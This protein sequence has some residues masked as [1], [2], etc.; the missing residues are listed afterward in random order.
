MLLLVCV[1]QL[2]GLKS[3]LATTRAEHAAE[4]QRMIEAAD[5]ER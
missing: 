3:D 5:S 1:L 2:M 4:K